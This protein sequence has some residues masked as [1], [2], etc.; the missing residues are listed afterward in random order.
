MTL[1]DRE[2]AG[3][4]RDWTITFQGRVYPMWVLME[5]LLWIVDKDSK[6]VPFHLN[7]QQ[8]GLY[9]E[10]CM[11]RRSGRP[12]RQDILKSRQIGYSTFIAGAFFLTGMF[13]PN[14]KIGVAADVEK[15]AKDIFAKYE[16]FYDHLD[17][18][19]PMKAEIDEFERTHKGQRH[20]ASYKPTLSYA[21][22]QT[23]MA[24]AAGN[25]VIEVIVAGQGS[26]RSNTYHM[27]HLS[28][29]A[30]FKDLLITMNGLLET[31]SSKN[32]ESFIFLETTANGFNEYKSRWDKDSQGLTSYGALFMPWF[33][34][35]EY[36]NED[37][38]DPNAVPPKM[39]QWFLDRKERFN[40]TWSQIV[41]YWDKYQDKGDLGLTLQ[42]YPFC[43][44]DAFITSGN[45]VF[46]TELIAKR[47]EELMPNLANVRRGRF[48]TKH[49]FSLDGKSVQFESEG[50][51]ECNG[52]EIAIYEEPKP[53]HPYICNLDPAMG[54][55]DSYVIQVLDNYEC[56][57]VAT[58]R[59]DRPGGD[60]EV[61]Y[62]L[63]AL[64]L[65]YN[66]AMI[67]AECNNSNGSYILQ[68]ASR[69]GYRNIYQDSEY[70][71]LSDSWENRFGYKTKQSNKAPMVTMLKLA[72]RDD[73]TMISDFQ[74]LCEME[75][76]GVFKT[77][78]G[79]ET[80]R[81]DSGSHDDTV[82][83]LMGCF[84]VR[85]S[86]AWD[87]VPKQAPTQTNENNDA[88]DPFRAAREA[89]KRNQA[90]KGRFI[91]WH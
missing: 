70:E 34:N 89:K 71:A 12:V 37:Y 13:T 64:G 54:G 69:C 21:R 43:A 44:T 84:L 88:Q 87:C 8:I 10:I 16:Y 9:K 33:S 48:V 82:T 77:V 4:E 1:A 11:Q 47:K 27:L 22:G 85:A 25:S 32:R 60:D 6:R 35:P 56:R 75:E 61:A 26:G 73:Y 28:E 65:H 14:L 20:R 23:M 51:L 58:Y 79:K 91:T 67:C 3:Y 52:G 57:Q 59:T 36:R 86:G 63:V 38:D 49:Q 80:Y 15:H 53:G 50:F 5:R 55:E 42:E 81:A 74:T 66:G 31:V 46:S 83:A 18:S 19:N 7:A 90:K 39:D 76:F 62:Q 2:L 29:C 68:L 41:W 17:D 45:C 40:L 72:F 24:T 30:F 78:G